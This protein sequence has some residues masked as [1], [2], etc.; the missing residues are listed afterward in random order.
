[1]YLGER[2]FSLSIVSPRLGVLCPWDLSATKVA[3]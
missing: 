1:M 2:R 3:R